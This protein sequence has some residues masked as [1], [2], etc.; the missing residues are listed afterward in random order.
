MASYYV[1]EYVHVEGRRTI[2][3]AVIHLGTCAACRDGNGTPQNAGRRHRL[4]RW[5]GPFA[6][7]DGALA[8]AQGIAGAAGICKRCAPLGPARHL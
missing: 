7:P 6:G 2:L 5:H 3:R 8:V 4:W 1:Y